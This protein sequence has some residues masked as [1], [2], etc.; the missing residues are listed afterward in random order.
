MREHRFK[1]TVYETLAM[2]YQ[3]YGKRLLALGILGFF[4]RLLVLS[5]ANIIG[6]WVDSFCTNPDLCK[7]PPSVFEEFSNTDFLYLLTFLTIAGFLLNTV[8]RIFFSR[9]SCQAV[10]QI[11]DEVTYRVSR[12]PIRFFDTTPGGKIITRFSSDYASI[13]RMFGGPLVEILG[14]TFDLLGILLLVTIASPYFLPIFVL[15]GLTDWL[16]FRYHRPYLRKQR[17]KLSASRAP[18]ISHFAETAQGASTIRVFSKTKAFSRRF[19]KLND[20][21]LAEKL[22]TIFFVNRFGFHLNGTTAL[23]L[24]IVGAAGYG[25]VMAG[26]TS[27]GSVGVAFGFVT[28]AGMN[29][30]VLFEW[31]SNFE[32][33][34]VGVERL[35][36]Y[37]RLPIEEGVSLPHQ[38]VFSTG[39]T[40]LKSAFKAPSFKTNQA[41]V[42]FDNVWLRYDKTLP[43]V[44]K[45]LNFTVKPG[46]K[47]G[48]VGKTG[49]GKS[50]IIQAL[51]YLYPIQKGRISIGGHSP[52]REHDEIS[53]YRKRIALIAQEPVL[54]SGTLKENLDLTGQLDDSQLRQAL[55]IVGLSK[56]VQNLEL[57]I[58]ERGRNLSLGER[59]LVC[60]ARCLLQEAPVVVMDEA[61]SSIDP[62]SES[63]LVKA[64]EEFFVDRTQIIVAHRLSTLEKCHR[65][66]WLDQG[67]AR[68][69]DEP[70]RVLKEF[71]QYQ[72]HTPQ[73]TL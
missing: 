37:L 28:L 29:L 70:Q 3:T 5:N 59:Q 36:R 20:G 23:L 32:E 50:S 47:F 38:S 10:S 8:Y 13:L 21:M 40:T 43:M 60:V 51:Y 56:W 4:G 14:V 6:Y 57:I 64:T 31:L 7:K 18:A 54:L 39:H 52:I 42:K 24:L 67:Q 53:Q 16:V 1:K 72:R 49:S 27:L 34:L 9:A 65:I 73:R 19:S 48:I 17:R 30:H 35:D 44:L 61:T 69:L 71:K 63:Y 22:K 68:M 2:A 33:A 66:L 26:L 58:E 15:M 55:D 11:Y 46:E 12:Y 62:K 25:L 41:E 45:D